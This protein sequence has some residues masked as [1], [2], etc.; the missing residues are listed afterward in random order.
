MEER[1]ISL[2]GLPDLFVGHHGQE[3]GEGVGGVEE[4]VLHCP[5]PSS[6]H[7][8]LQAPGHRGDE[9]SNRKRHILQEGGQIH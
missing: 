6:I 4:V 5:Q 2:P 8:D 7:W 3:A 1:D 9:E